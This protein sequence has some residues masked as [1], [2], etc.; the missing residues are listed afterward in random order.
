M[1]RYPMFLLKIAKLETPKTAL[2]QGEKSFRFKYFP[3]ILGKHLHRFF[4]LMA[5]RAACIF[6]ATK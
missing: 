1:C 3:N 4:L 2:R 6:A 5:E